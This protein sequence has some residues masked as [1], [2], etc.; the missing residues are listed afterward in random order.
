[1]T[2]YI[3][4]ESHP[5]EGFN[6]TYEPWLFHD[7]RHRMLQSSAGWHSF[8]VVNEKHQR[9]EAHLHI[10][11]EGTLAVS[12]LK[13]S[14]GSVQCAPSI[15]RVVLYKFLEYI[16]SRLKDIGVTTITLKNPPDH[17]QPAQAVFLNTFLFNVGFQVATAEVGAALPVTTQAFNDGLSTWEKRRMR[18]ATEAGLVF[19][20]SAA[21]HAEAIYNFI[22]ACRAERGYTLAIDAITFLK[23]F[24]TF[25][26]RFFFF[27]VQDGEK[28]CA[29]SIAIHVGNG[30]L[31]NFHSAHPREYDNLSPV[32]LLLGGMY[33]FC[34]QHGFS[35]LDLGTS[36]HDDI[37]NFSL[38]D[39]KL[40]LGAIPSMKLVFTKSL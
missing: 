13:A 25:P 5:P 28:R 37:P 18:Q 11:V 21:E 1:L 15:P 19:S 33:D 4:Q 17:Y 10:H 16:Q 7:Q 35:L 36:A 14:F 26:D 8:Y 9:I 40:G 27:S 2:D 38:L 3:F 24:R 31:Y 12:P 22:A 32:V 29:A 23:T 6:Y 30:I 34:S 39:F 20:V